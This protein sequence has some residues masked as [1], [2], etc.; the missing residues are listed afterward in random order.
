MKPRCLFIPYVIASERVES[1]VT[2][3]PVGEPNTYFETEMTPEEAENFALDLLNEARKAKHLRSSRE[4]LEKQGA[5]SG[6]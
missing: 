5:D 3:T 1:V 2:R 4:W 6:F